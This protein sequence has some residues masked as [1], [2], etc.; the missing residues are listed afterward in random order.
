MIADSAGR[1]TRLSVCAKMLA[2]AFVDVAAERSEVRVITGVVAV[3]ALDRAR[4]DAPTIFNLPGL[5]P[6]RTRVAMN[7]VDQSLSRFL[8]DREVLLGE[9]L[10]DQ[11]VCAGFL[12]E[13]VIEIE[14]NQA[15]TPVFPDIA[16]CRFSHDGGPPADLV[17]RFRR[18]F[19]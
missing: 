4:A 9:L 7:R 14:N 6:K 3:E 18:R 8:A 19:S 10:D 12:N 5:L 11:S 13:R 1:P 15:R 16:S 17:A 2:S